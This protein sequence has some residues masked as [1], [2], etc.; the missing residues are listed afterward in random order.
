MRQEMSR[1]R[2]LLALI[3]LVF[4][5]ASLW[6]WP[7]WSAIQ[8]LRSEPNLELTVQTSSDERWREISEPLVWLT[9]NHIGAV[10]ITG[11]LK[12]PQA[13]GE[14]LGVIGPIDEISCAKEMDGDV[15]G[16][17]D[18][19]PDGQIVRRL[20]LANSRLTDAASSNFGRV[21][22]LKE[23]SFVGS[24]VT[25]EQWPTMPSL[26]DVDLAYSPITDAGLLRVATS[27]P[28]LKRLQVKNGSVTI[29]GVEA[30]LSAHSER[31]W[32]VVVS[33]VPGFTEDWSTRLSKTYPETDLRL[34]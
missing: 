27:C 9:A 25:G 3:G 20:Y 4:C 19:L 21:R 32:I 10:M 34:D 24:M 6:M 1:F 14:A 13:V 18:G 22:E 16:L 17:L 12:S 23:A 15:N 26:E 29:S 28:G 5:L 11:R 30:L 2:K 33:G 8:Y 31:K 7:R